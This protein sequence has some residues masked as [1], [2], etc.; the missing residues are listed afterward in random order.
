MGPVVGPNTRVLLFLSLLIVRYFYIEY[1]MNFR[2][3][4]SR[5]VVNG[6]QDVEMVNQL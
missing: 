2:S 6:M 1:P 3:L 4:P 5:G